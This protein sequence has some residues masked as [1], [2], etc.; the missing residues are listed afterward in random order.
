MQ[1][2]FLGLIFAGAAFS[3][4]VGGAL[5]GVVR[6]ETGT[7]IP[8][9]A[10]TVHNLETGAGRKFLTESSGHF[11]AASIAVGPYE[12]TAAKEGFATQTKTGIDLLVGQTASVDFTLA[13]G[14]VRQI[15]TGTSGQLLGVDAVREFNVVTDTYGAEYGKRPAAQVSIITASGTNQL[16]G[17]LYEFLRNS[18]LDARN[19]FD[20][21]GTPQFQRNVFG[22]SLRGPVRKNKLFLFGNYEGF[23]QHLALSNVT[24]V[25]DN[26]ARLGLI[27][28]ASGKLTLLPGGVSPASA[29]LLSPWPV[30]N[31]PSLGGG[32][33]INYN[34]P[35]QRIREDF[36]TIFG[37]CLHHRRQQCQHALGE[38]AQQ[39]V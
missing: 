39:R 20:Q 23:R 22:G 17:V 6:D 35:L 36:G 10:V 29:A 1:R 19:F 33:G 13:V 4:V 24:L 11:A 14:E 12:V 37:V 2:V 38:S 26:N 15:V 5:S 32:I 28:N 30:Q 9:S 18:A 31:G 25:P 21:G 7:A 3:Q 27:S 8:G 34:N 16:H